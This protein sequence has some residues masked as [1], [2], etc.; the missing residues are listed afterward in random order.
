VDRLPELRYVH[1]VL[2]ADRR[3]LSRL[4]AEVYAGHLYEHFANEPQTEASRA[5]VALRYSPMPRQ[6]RKHDG[7]WA[8]ADLYQ[9]L[10][11]TG[12]HLTDLRLEAGT[13]WRLSDRI[14]GALWAVHHE[15]TGESPFRFDD[16]W[17]DDEGF[18]S[19]DLQLDPKQR[20]QLY[21]HYDFDKSSFRDYSAKYSYRAHCL[22]WNLEYNFARQSVSVGVDL[23]GLT[24]ETRPV[25]SAPLVRPDE[26]PPLPEP[27]PEPPASA[28]AAPATPPS[29]ATP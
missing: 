10:Y 28:P 24:G 5:G 7:F 3:G 22:T 16:V 17:A 29:A 8:A 21:G 6:R 19:V 15:S 2:P 20:L 14:G 26:V 4:E 12:D 1:H 13:G 27:T 25:T 9:T 23:N 18:A 11:D